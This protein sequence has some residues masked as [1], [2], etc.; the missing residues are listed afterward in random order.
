[1][2]ASHMSDTLSGSV[3]PHCMPW[4]ICKQLVMLHDL[5][6]FAS[7]SSAQIWHLAYA[8]TVVVTFSLRHHEPLV[9]VD[10]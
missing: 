2:I 6:V 3:S 4:S 8:D 5:Y 1:M 9:S 10:S 7:G